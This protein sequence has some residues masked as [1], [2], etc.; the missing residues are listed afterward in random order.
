MNKLFPGVCVVLVLTA[1][2]LSCSRKPPYDAKVIDQSELDPPAQQE[3]EVPAG[4]GGK[5]LKERQW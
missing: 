4:G 5:A 1:L 2:S 3:R